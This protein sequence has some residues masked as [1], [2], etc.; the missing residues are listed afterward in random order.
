[1][2]GLEDL[3]A[4]NPTLAS[5][6]RAIGM[7]KKEWKDAELPR[8]M[9]DV[10]IR[11]N[12]LGV[13][14]RST[15]PEDVP[16]SIKTYRADPKNKSRSGTG[17]ETM[18]ISR[19]D[20]GGVKGSKP[21]EGPEDENVYNN[22]AKANQELYRYARLAGAAEKYGYPSLTADQLAAFALKEGRSDY[23]F[24]GGDFGVTGSNYSNKTYKELQS[25]FN[26][27]PQDLGFIAHIADKQRV[28]DKHNIPFAHAWNGTGKNLKGTSG[29]E[30]AKDWEFHRQAALR[31]ENKPLMDLIQKGINDGKKFGLPL[32]ETKDKDTI[33]SFKETSYK[34]GG[35]VEKAISGGSKLI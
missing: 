26:A 1:M 9:R 7:K 4:N 34:K 19:F 32:L 30:Y 5:V 33:G 17:I 12:P 35:F 14:P 8:N 6:A 27:H 21:A 28:A 31:D 29:A 23:G 22:A 10:D 11:Y 13:L 16:S 25:K 20:V 24:N 3:I 2:A 15:R 18:P